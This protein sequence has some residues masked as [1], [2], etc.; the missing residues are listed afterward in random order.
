MAKCKAKP[1]MCTCEKVASVII[2]MVVVFLL[3]QKLARAEQTGMSAPASSPEFQQ[4]T[5]L[6]G[7]WKGTGE[8]HG[9]P[10][11]IVTSFRVT[12]GGTVIEENLMPGTPEEMVDM[13]TDENGKLTMTHYCTMGNQ[14]HLVLK[15]STP[16]EIALE[17]SSGAGI[18]VSKDHHMHALT[19]EFPDANHLTE[20]W[21]SY[22]DGK[23]GEVVVFKLARAN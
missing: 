15:K 4:M 17:M 20:K 16:T 22:H 12:S 8:M 10:S 23:P 14:P 1:G 9:K 3:Y 11:Q 5:H 7:T 2:A 21:T 6:V 18:D 19:L 13:Y